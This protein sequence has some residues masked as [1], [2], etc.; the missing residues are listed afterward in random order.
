MGYWYL[1]VYMFMYS[2]VCHCSVCTGIY[3][4]THTLTE[5]ST[6]FS[7]YLHYIIGVFHLSLPTCISYNHTATLITLHCPVPGDTDKLYSTRIFI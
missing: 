7:F 4:R 1:C 6:H 3:T 2:C 5:N